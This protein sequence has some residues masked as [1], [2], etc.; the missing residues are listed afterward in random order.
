MQPIAKKFLNVIS[1]ISHQA[2][3]NREA[4]VKSRHCM[5]G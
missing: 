3:G 4:T 2:L 5:S 1:G